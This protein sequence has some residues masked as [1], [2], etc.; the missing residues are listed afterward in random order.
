MFSSSSLVLLSLVSSACANV[1]ITSPV[2]TS[3]FAAGQPATVS[4]K[5]DGAVPSLASFGAASIALYVGNSFQQTQLQLISPSVD[6]STSGSISFTP[7]ASVGSNGADYFIRFD[8]LALKDATNSQFPA[9][10]FSAKFTLTG[11]TGTFSPEVQSQ[12]DGQSTAPLAG[13]T[14]AAQTTAGQTTA[15]K[16]TTTG[17]SS[18]KTSASGSKTGTGAN[19]AKTNGASVSFNSGSAKMWIGVLAGVVV[20][21]L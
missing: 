18:V 11:M 9:Q 12:I 6:V 14:T 19:A 10:A 15:A 3:S 16:P 5:D 20:G 4:W 17:A 21:V 1:F 13:A 2:A 8:S 7:T